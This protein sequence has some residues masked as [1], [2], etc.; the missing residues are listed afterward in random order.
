MFTLEKDTVE[1]FEFNIKGNRTK[2]KIPMVR[3]LPMDLAL[4][5]A[6]IENKSNEEIMAFVMNIFN[7]YAPGVVGGLTGGEF[8]RLYQAYFEASGTNMGE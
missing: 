8:E 1:Y 5:A 2:Y 3:Y 4:E 6:G 7:Q